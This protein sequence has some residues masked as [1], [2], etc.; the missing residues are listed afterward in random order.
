MKVPSSIYIGES[1]RE[2]LAIYTFFPDIYRAPPPSASD[3]LRVA[4]ADYSYEGFRRGIDIFL[5]K[6]YLKER[7][8]VGNHEASLYGTDLNFRELDYKR[9]I[10]LTGKLEFVDVRNDIKYDMLAGFEHKEEVLNLIRRDVL[11]FCEEEARKPT[12]TRIELVEEIKPKMILREIKQKE[13]LRGGKQEYVPSC[14]LDANL[15]F[16]YG[17]ISGMVNG[18]FLDVFAECDYCYS[19][20]NHKTFSKYIVHIDKEQLIEE[21]KGGY[22]KQWFKN[23]TMLNG[24]VSVL[25]LGKRTESGSKYTLDKLVTTLEACQEA[26]TRAVM[27]TK[28]LEFNKEIAE[29]FKRTKSSLLY[30]IGWDELERGACS[31]GCNNEFRI[32]QAIKFKEAGVNPIIYLLIDLPYPPTKRELDIIKKAE[33]QKLRIQ[34]LPVRMGDSETALKITGKAWGNLKKPLSHLQL[35]LKGISYDVCGGGYAS[36]AGTLIAQ[37]KDPYWLKLVGNNKGNVRMCH[38]D[39][40]ETY[41]GNCFLKGG[42][43]IPTKQVDIKYAHVRKANW[44]RKR[45]NKNLKLFN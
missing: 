42:F 6:T 43:I 45:P 12:G 4:H 2:Y 41:C 30:S 36:N 1:G 16:S 34:L 7:R 18:G 35:A 29:L 9:A 40:K 44:K 31:H 11:E 39:E 8:D 25:R 33:E 15:D 38:H 22:G 19:V 5:I 17:C 23:G 3:S 26:G 14:G 10:S 32:E 37:E 13:L 21:L 20:Y 28:Y 27:P 24:P